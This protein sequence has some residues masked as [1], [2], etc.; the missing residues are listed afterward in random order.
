M[1]GSAAG[2]AFLA[3]CG[4]GDEDDDGP[5]SSSSSASSGAAEQ[6]GLISPQVDTIDQAKPGGTLRTPAQTDIRSH[7]PYLRDASVNYHTWLVYSFL[8]RSKSNAFSLASPDQVIPD[9]A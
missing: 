4:G 5:S 2:A 3:A 1:G 8:V 7:Q 9:G 6:S